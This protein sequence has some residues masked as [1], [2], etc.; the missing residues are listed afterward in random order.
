MS[1]PNPNAPPGLLA[2]LA[3]QKRETFRTKALGGRAIRPQAPPPNPHRFP[4]L[5]CGSF[6]GGNTMMAP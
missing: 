3:E 6:G 5:P 1:V 4:I 2:V